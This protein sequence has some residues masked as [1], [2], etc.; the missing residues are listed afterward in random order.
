MISRKRNGNNLGY[1]DQNSGKNE[2]TKNSIAFKSS[3]KPVN[4]IKSAKENKYDY[5]VE[6]IKP[7]LDSI[8]LNRFN[9]REIDVIAFSSIEG[10]L[11]SNMKLQKRIILI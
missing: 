5:Q 1:Q 8:Q 11:L 9:I 2:P 3:G 10:N 6:D 4:S 7:F